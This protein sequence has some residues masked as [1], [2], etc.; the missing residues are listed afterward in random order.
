MT[1]N[2]PIPADPCQTL[3]NPICVELSPSKENGADAQV[4]EG[5]SGACKSAGLRLRWFQPSPTHHFDSAE[6]TKVEDF[7]EVAALAHGARHH[8]R[9][10]LLSSL[11]GAKGILRGIG[12][13]A[14][15][16]YWKRFLPIRCL[17]PATQSAGH[18]WNPSAFPWSPVT[19]GF[20]QGESQP[21]LLRADA[22]KIHP[23]SQ[24]CRQMI[25]RRLREAHR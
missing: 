6:E 13:A 7:L 8:T 17:L 4:V 3:E 14:R 11:T 18:S 15:S 16:T 20:Q 5:E 25:S 2:Q 12:V 21:L 19:S 24:N 22:L 9:I 1:P 23:R 10:D